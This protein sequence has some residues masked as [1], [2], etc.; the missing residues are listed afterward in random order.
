MDT[1]GTIHPLKTLELLN[2]RLKK[3]K[4][5]FK[6]L[7]FHFLGGLWM[8]PRPGCQPEAYC[9]SLTGKERWMETGDLTAKSMQLGRHAETGVL[10]ARNLNVL[11]I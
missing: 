2:L 11:R 9:I 8:I 7:P 10:K 3:E 1:L 5:S 6:N 4:K